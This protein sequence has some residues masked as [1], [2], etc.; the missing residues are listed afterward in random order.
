MDTRFCVEALDEA[1][2]RYEMPRQAEIEI[3]CYF[4]FYNEK[5]RHQGLERRTSDEVY[6]T[7]LVNEQKAA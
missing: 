2:A 5:R 4:R 7:D 1:L 6:Y 3:A